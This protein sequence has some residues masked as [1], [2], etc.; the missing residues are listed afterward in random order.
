MGCNYANLVR[1]WKQG[2]ENRCAFCREPDANSEEEEIKRVMK[3][4]KKHNDPVAMIEIGKRRYHE[5]DYGKALQ[6]YA[7]AAELGDLDA[8]FLLGGLYHHGQGVEKDV[9]KAV[10]HLEQAAIGGHPLA[11]S[12]LADY[13]VKNKRPDRAVKH[14][15][16]A[17]NLG[18]ERSVKELREHYSDG[19]MNKDD[20]A[21]ALRGYQSAVNETKSAGREKAELPL[22]GL[23]LF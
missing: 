1:E 23:G 5:G 9:K 2:L 4:I 20:Y 10:D 13:E 18:H 7:K 15:I 22:M 17:A 16:I 6:Y 12:I 3:R 8:Q 11:R 21:A 19:N 14:L